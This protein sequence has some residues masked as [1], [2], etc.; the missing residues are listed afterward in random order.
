MHKFILITLSLLLFSSHA[1]AEWKL[2]GSESNLQ[3]ISIKKSSVAE[4]TTLN[5]SA[6]TLTHKVVSR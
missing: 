5:Q 6:V 2:N 4:S 1:L 3:F